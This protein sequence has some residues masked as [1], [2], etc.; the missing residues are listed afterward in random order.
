MLIRN[1]RI[2]TMD[3]Q[4]SVFENGFVAVTGDRISQIGE[5][6]DL[7]VEEDAHPLHAKKSIDAQG[8]F[9]S[10]D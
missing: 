1:A 5:E 6:D 9:A 10:P 8:G 3:A 4:M 7:L 2:L